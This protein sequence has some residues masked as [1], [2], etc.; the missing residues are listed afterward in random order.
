MVFRIIFVVVPG[1][2]LFLISS[3]SFGGE[4]CGHW[5]GSS[6]PRP[7]T[8]FAMPPISC[9]LPLGGVGSPFH[10]GELFGYP[11]HPPGSPS[12]ARGVFFTNSGRL[13]SRYAASARGFPSIW[14]CI[15]GRSARWGRR[16]LRCRSGGENS[17][18]PLSPPSAI[19][20]SSPP[21]PRAC[22]MPR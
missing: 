14:W 12:C 9:P 22:P 11:F 7:L 3:P 4:K 1:P 8:A 17:T 18:A 20:P 6:V 21:L 10:L 15:Q 16:A 2:S 13:C 5:W 19:H